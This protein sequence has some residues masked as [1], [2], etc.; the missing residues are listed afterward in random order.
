MIC[1]FGNCKHEHDL[2]IKPQPDSDVIPICRNCAESES[3]TYHLSYDHSKDPAKVDN[4]RLA[5]DPDTALAKQLIDR[6]EQL[7]RHI[8]R[9]EG[10]NQKA[11][12]QLKDIKEQLDTAV[13]KL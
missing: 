3:E 11:I 2:W 1:A 10:D 6:S 9:Y 7:Q 8:T 5:Y 4:Y 13:G 12:K